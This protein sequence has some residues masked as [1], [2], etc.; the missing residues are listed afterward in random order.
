MDNGHVIEKKIMRE[1]EKRLTETIEHSWSS[2][3]EG[4]IESTPRQ[5]S[6][7]KILLL[8]DQNLSDEKFSD[9]SGCMMNALRCCRQYK[10]TKVR[11]KF[12]DGEYGNDRFMFQKTVRE[13]LASLKMNPT[14]SGTQDDL[15]SFL[16]EEII[17]KKCPLILILADNNL[18]EM[19]QKME[20]IL[21]KKLIT[22]TWN[23]NQ[24]IKPVN[25]GISI[26]TY[27]KKDIGE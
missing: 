24:E 13:V 10:N 21:Y 26:F 22:L 16:R 8:I 20:Q 18:A 4:M 2:R 11:I 1:L 25:S 19:I 3:I 5:G 12:W 7:D 6:F 27:M 17:K 9:L 15:E 23:N 14:R